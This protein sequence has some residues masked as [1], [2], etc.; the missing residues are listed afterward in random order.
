MS[1]TSIT[2]RNRII[3]SGL[4]TGHICT[5]KCGNAGSLAHFRLKTS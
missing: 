1:A 3:N 4:Q 2:V 5:P